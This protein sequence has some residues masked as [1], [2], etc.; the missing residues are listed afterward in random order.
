MAKQALVIAQYE[1]EMEKKKINIEMQNQ[2]IAKGIR[3]KV[4]LEE[5]EVDLLALE[6][7]S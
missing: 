6:I 5:K 1:A 4:Q 3:I 2:K 7:L